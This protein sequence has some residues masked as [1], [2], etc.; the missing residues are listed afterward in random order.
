M[1]RHSSHRTR[2]ALLIAVAALLIVSIFLV[3]RLVVAGK[4]PAWR[5][6]GLPGATV[7]SLS[8]DPLRSGVVFAAAETGVYRRDPRGAWQRVLRANI[9]WSVQA[10]PDGRTVI[11]GDQA[12]TVYVSRDLGHHWTGRSV[13]PMGVYAVSG[14]PG[15]PHRLL[16]G[17]GGGVYL[18]V[19]GGVHWRR[20]LALPNAAGAAFAWRPGTVSTVFAGSV[21]GAVGGSTRVFISRDS[22][23]HWRVFGRALGS[24]GGIMSLAVPT[25]H[26]DAGTMGN[27]LWTIP[28]TGGRWQQ[29][30]A[31]VPPNQHISGI[32]AVPGPPETF[33]ATLGTGVF[34]SND[35]GRRWATASDGLP[36]VDH[37]QIVLSL[38]YVP[39]EH[40]L[41]AGTTDG[42]FRM[43][44][45]MP[46]S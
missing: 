29:H 25:G 21:A 1:T 9:V 31:G 24:Q 32:A 23:L 35:G 18:S 6:D 34:R 41:Y 13:T 19:D 10:L 33:I 42:V 37:S 16:A 30:V 39:G 5:Q 7:H 2:M 15:H 45:A 27:R 38:A 4:A 46:T 40:A 11:A 20:R 22:G 26:L 14:Q 17:A 28:L 43:H 44:I 3:L 36:S 8:V 12:G